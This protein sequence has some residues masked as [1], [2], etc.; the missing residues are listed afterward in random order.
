L[1]KKVL[2]AK[3]LSSFWRRFKGL[4][5][6]EIKDLV[7]ADEKRFEGFLEDIKEIPKVLS[8]TFSVDVEKFSEEFMFAC[9]E[10]YMKQ[11]DIKG[12]F[13]LYFK[14][15]QIKDSTKLEAELHKL[16]QETWKKKFKLKESRPEGL[17]LTVFDP[18]DLYFNYYH[19]YLYDPILLHN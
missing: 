18:S 4:K 3:G 14:N 6:L 1:G 5:E 16:L 19:D 10:K 7:F 15:M 8:M 13:K 12:A 11:V 17:M 2:W 9:L